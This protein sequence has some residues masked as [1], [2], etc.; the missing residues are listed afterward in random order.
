M[1]EENE[2]GSAIL[3]H[4]LIGLFPAFCATCLHR[5]PWPHQDHISNTQCTK[6]WQ[7]GVSCQ[8]RMR[9]VT[10]QGTGPHQVVFTEVGME[11]ECNVTVPYCITVN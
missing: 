5:S 10:S 9:Q 8:E 1:S 11:S 3:C 2:R 4:C 7:R 6:S